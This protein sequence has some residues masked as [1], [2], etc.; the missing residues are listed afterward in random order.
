METAEGKELER[1]I[2]AGD[3]RSARQFATTVVS[4]AEAPEK[5][6]S[7]AQQLLRG[8][9]PDPVARVLIGL[10]GLGLLLVIL[11]YAG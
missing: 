2:T 7:E 6:K 11:S 1:L 8:L 4:S 5:A 3:Y 9:K 10:V